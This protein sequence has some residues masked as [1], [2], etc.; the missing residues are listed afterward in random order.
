M[1]DINRTI[2][3]QPLFRRVQGLM[4]GRVVMITFLWL[5]LVTVEFTTDPTPARLPLSYIILIT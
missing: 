3:Q 5:A 4:L 1:S 2:G